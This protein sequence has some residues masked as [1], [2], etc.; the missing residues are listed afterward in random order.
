L[1]IAEVDTSAFS[2]GSTD[3]FIRA[4]VAAM[5]SAGGELYL[6]AAIDTTANEGVGVRITS[7]GTVF[8]EQEDISTA[9]GSTIWRSSTSWDTVAA[10]DVITLCYRNGTLLFFINDDQ[11]FIWR[12]HPSRTVVSGQPGIG[13]GNVQSSDAARFDDVE[14]G[15][16]ADADIHQEGVWLHNRGGGT[17]DY[18]TADDGTQYTVPATTTVTFTNIK[19]DTEVRVYATGTT[20]EIAGTENA[21]TGSPDDRSFAW[22]ADAGTVVD[23]VLIN[24]AGWQIIRVEGYTVPSSNTSLPIQQVIERNYSN[25]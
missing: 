7:N 21:T 12:P 16:I 13:F 14:F 15:E 3:R 4:T 25:P 22:S 6:W 10:N 11:V 1:N 17:F 18:F 2:F 23:Y 8:F 20:T 9:A 24:V 19:D 5:P